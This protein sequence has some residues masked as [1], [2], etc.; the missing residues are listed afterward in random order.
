MI[1]ILI[2]SWF[3]VVELLRTRMTDR[4]TSLSVGVPQS[5]RS[6]SGSTVFVGKLVYQ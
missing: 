4:G 5:K 1:L 6:D 2:W 3:G